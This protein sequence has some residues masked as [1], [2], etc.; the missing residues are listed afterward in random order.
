MYIKHKVGH[1]KPQIQSNSGIT[2]GSDRIG[3]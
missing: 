2:F 1:G 3:I